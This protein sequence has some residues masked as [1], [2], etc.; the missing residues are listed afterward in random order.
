MADSIPRRPDG[1][2]GIALVVALL[3]LMVIS[4]LATVL[5]MSVNVDTKITGHGLR[6]T[7]ALNYAEAGIGE[8]QARIATGDIDLNSNPRAVAQIFNTPSGNVPV[9]GTDSTG[10][11]T[12]QPTGAWL[13]YSTASRGP[14]ALTVHYRT[15]A[16]RSVIYRYDPNQNPAVQTASGSPIYVITSTG[17]AG[18]DARTVCA[19]IY[20]KPITAHTFGAMVANVSVSLKGTVDVCGHNHSVSMPT[21][22]GD[23]Y[24]TG[25]GDLPGTWSSGG[26]SVQGAAYTDGNPGLAQNQT[27]PYTGPNGFYAGPW[28][29]LGM[30]QSQFFSWIGPAVS[31]PDPPMG[32][33]YINGSAAYNGGDGQ[34]VLYVTGNLVM[35]GNF[36][37]RGLIYVEGD[38]QINGGAWVLGGLIVKGITEV[39][40]ANGNASVFY[41]SE[42]ISQAASSAGGSFQRLSWREIPSL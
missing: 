13:A 5:M 17:T 14:R 34:G 20:S 38:L 4:M 27:G 28:D 40:L 32:L 25:T 3:V 39:K 23:G 22:A 33:V 7:E 42:M 29:A 9:L 18:T 16:A 21:G 30:T 26:V 19:E 12:A 31:P 37:Y 36:T 24:H 10:L 35:N 11:A 1:E 6:V 41:S 8:A 15:D 2:R